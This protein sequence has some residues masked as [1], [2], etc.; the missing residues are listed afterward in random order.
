MLVWRLAGLP[1]VGRE[2]WEIE[3]RHNTFNRML[4]TLRAPDY[5][6]VAF[7]V[8][9]I[10]RR[11][12]IRDGSKFSQP[13][14]Q[15]LSDEYYASLSG[16]KLM[17][18]ELYLTMIYR[19]VVEG[20]R[21]VEKSA[22]IERLEQEQAQAIGTILELAGNVEAVLKDY[23]PY[24]LGLYEAP[25]GIIFSEILE[26][27]GYILN[28]LDEPVPSLRAPIYEYLPVSRQRFL[29]EDRRLRSHHT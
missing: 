25:N 22:N 3:H 1:F 9:D 26:L 18:N 14:N 29:G 11:R 8:H 17:Q 16:Q 27:Y 2:E 21:W 28:R 24:R 15:A 6:N 19:P 13:F 5:P 20:K 7:W 10:R 23:A 12:P 4:Q